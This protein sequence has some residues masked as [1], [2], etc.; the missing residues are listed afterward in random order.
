M[1]R[2][3]ASVPT[4]V[5]DCGLPVNAGFKKLREI[6]RLVSR[7]RQRGESVL[8]EV[9]VVVLLVI[10]E[11]E[12]L[13]APV[14]DFRNVDGATQR[15]ALVVL[16]VYG[17]LIALGFV[18]EA[19]GVEGLVLPIP[20]S[21]AVQI[22]GAGLDVEVGDRGL[23]AVILSAYRAG[24]QFELADRFGGRTEFVVVA[25]GEIGAARPECLRSESRASTPGRR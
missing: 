12:C 3:S 16:P 17:L 22:V 10:H 24:L 9:A 5:P 18:T 6:A 11:P 20:E 13:I 14:V 23:P 4:C 19:L 25:A 15:K 7:K 21:R 2:P 1:G 8:A